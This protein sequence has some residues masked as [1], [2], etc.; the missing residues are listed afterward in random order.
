MANLDP[1][2]TEFNYDFF[3][4]LFWDKMQAEQNRKING[5]KCGDGQL[6]DRPEPSKRVPK[7]PMEVVIL[8]LGDIW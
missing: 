6:L 2:I 4:G 8:H 3:L 1:R 7:H 5:G